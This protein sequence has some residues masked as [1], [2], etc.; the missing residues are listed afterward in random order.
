MKYSNKIYYSSIKLIMARRDKI[1]EEECNIHLKK[2]K[3]AHIFLKE[4]AI[5]KINAHLHTLKKN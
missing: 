2:L 4:N 3:Y 5:D 1:L